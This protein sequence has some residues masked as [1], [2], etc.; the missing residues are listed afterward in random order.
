MKTS[1]LLFIL[2]CGYGYIHG[3]SIEDLKTKLQQATSADERMD[4]HLDL[5]ELL[6]S[7]DGKEAGT[8][9]RKAFDIAN[10]QKNYSMAAQSA[11]V[12]AK[13]YKK[14]RDDRNTEI[15]LKSTLKYAKQAKD[16]DLIIKSVD[17]RSK[18]AIKKKNYRRA[19]QINQ[20]AFDYFS[21][22][23]NSLS[24][25]ER[26]YNK[27]KVVLKKETDDMKSDKR[28][29][30]REIARLE[31]EKTSLSEDKTELTKQQEVLIQAKEQTDSV[32]TQ[33]EE[34]LADLEEAKVEAEERAKKK[35]KAYKKLEKKELAQRL[36]VKEKE[37]EL[38]VIE[39]AAKLENEKNRRNLMLAGLGAFSMVLL[40]LV[41]YSRYRTKKNANDKLE[42]K[43]KIIEEE[44][45]RSDEL[46]LNILPADIAQELKENGKAKAQK[47][48]DASVLLADFKNF[49]AISERLTPEQLVKELD[50]CFRGFDFIISQY[51]GLEKI[52]TIGDAY[53]CA[54][55]LSNRKTVP[56]EIVKAALEMQ[57]FLEDYKNDRSKKGLQ[58][59]EARIGIHTGPVV[60][61]VVGVNKFAYDIWGDTVNIAS[62]L[63]SNCKEGQVNISAATYNQIRYKF[64]CE[65]RGKINAKNKG[66][67]DMYYV[68]KAV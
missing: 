32:L 40:A 1:L 43:N 24:K 67:I 37:N 28:H 21:N 47:F 49:T 17:E 11:Y 54:S 25:L 61:G 55:G 46:L 9:A 53:M 52:K 45:E 10:N 19:Y 63:E 44:R 65:Y 13:S 31:R 8:H 51:P 57:E 7:K 6:L 18:L 48:S 60:A 12:I 16:S 56:T 58:Y 4:I 34:A 5:S 22:T 68:K 30:E 41:F 15:W 38:M 27:Q 35:E 50:Y 36:A 39:N 26:T 62:R 33:K 23:D 66:Q 2:L 14:R 20:E 42:E 59:F 64:D 3:Q 29:L